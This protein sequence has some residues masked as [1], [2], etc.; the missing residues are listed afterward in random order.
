MKY[1]LESL[2]V[3][4]LTVLGCL[5]T[6]DWQ[7]VLFWHLCITLFGMLGIAWVAIQYAESLGLG[8]GDFTFD[9]DVM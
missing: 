5:I 1:L 7:A 3:I 8:D 6:Q 9:E 4:A 2:V